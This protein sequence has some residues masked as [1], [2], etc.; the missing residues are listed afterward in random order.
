M[1]E[2]FPDFS[3]AVSLIKYFGAVGVE[4][5][6]FLLCLGFCSALIFK[7]T[8]RLMMVRRDATVGLE[9]KAH[10]LG[11]QN[12]KIKEDYERRLDG[13]RHIA[14]EQMESAEMIGRR[15][16]EMLIGT[17]KSSASKDREN[18]I[19]SF[20]ESLD[21]IRP[22]AEKEIMH[23]SGDISNKLLNG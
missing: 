11:E 2:L 10:T 19:K 1:S 4:A 20:D 8:K 22:V 18:V 21:S 7:P 17:A 5:L 9:K 14:E 12:R 3:S 23:L 16:S 13:A 6:L 15:M